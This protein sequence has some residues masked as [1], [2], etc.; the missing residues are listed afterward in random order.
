MWHPRELNNYGVGVDPIHDNFFVQDSA[1]LAESLVRETLQ[2]SLDAKRLDLDTVRVRFSIKTVQPGRRNV[3]QALM[4]G[5]LP[6]LNSAKP[7]LYNAVANYGEPKVLVIE[8]FGTTGLEGDES[9]RQDDNNHFANFWR[10]VGR[11]EKGGARGGSFGI[12]KVVIP[13]SSLACT[14]FGVTVREGPG[15]ST[16]P[17]F[18][19]QSMLPQHKINGI[20]YEPF[21]LY[22]DLGED[23]V[24]PVS[25]TSR[26]ETFSSCLGF[27]RQLDQPGTSIAIPYPAKPIS[28]EAILNAVV[29][30]YFYSI[31]K[32]QLVVEI[33]GDDFPT[34]TLTRQS[35]K[36]HASSLG[37]DFLSLLGFIE[38]S[39]DV[40][41]SELL[42]LPY[43]PED[44]SIDAE[45]FEDSPE[46]LDE[47]R[48]KYENGELLSFIYSLPLAPLE[49]E[50]GCGDLHLFI[51][52]SP[53]VEKGCDVYMRSGISVYA[54]SVFKDSNKAFALLV[55][56][57]ELI[58]ELLRLSEGPA[59]N[60]WIFSSAKASAAYA[61]AAKTIK[62]AKNSLRELYSLLAV[63]KEEQ[64]LNSFAKFFPSSRKD[65]VVDPVGDVP[66][67]NIRAADGVVTI[68]KS[69]AAE[70]PTLVGMTAI[71]SANYVSPPGAKK[72]TKV[73]FDLTKRPPMSI[74]ADGALFHDVTGNKFNFKV[75]DDDFEIV[76]KTFDKLRDLEVRVNLNS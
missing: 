3:I 37:L 41:D 25:S 54:N 71:F 7:S 13:M 75:E 22:G 10:F 73:D 59:H 47:L 2:N 58:C 26:I 39:V 70:S 24:L 4:Q 31:I 19:G 56:D 67:F 34:V 5:I 32:G 36:H 65:E 11:T 64:D 21:I 68:T 57:E 50:P 44:L 27:T 33:E 38:A 74:T 15:N 63:G 49:G 76:V 20:N 6:H 16:G 40:P 53:N 55:A 51:K 28:C 48:K 17:L 35:I 29:K 52:K 61:G 14:F 8:D 18:M 72:Y 42:Q 43:R 66:K 23:I 69:Q 62:A 60:T 12:G 30:H 45:T 9:T 1:Q 46:V